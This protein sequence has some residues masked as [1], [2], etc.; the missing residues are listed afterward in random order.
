MFA[1]CEVRTMT[2]S[3][4][5][6]PAARPHRV[7]AVGALLAA[8]ALL[9]GACTANPPP[10]IQRTDSP[11]PT[12]AKPAK[13]TVVVAID[14]I[15]TGFNPHLVS[16]QS[17]AG[18]TVSS[19]VLPSPF[20]PVPN[21]ARPGVSDWVPDRSMLVAADVTSQVPFT[22]VYRIRDEAQWS[23][24]AP[25]AAEDFRYLWQQMIVQEGVVDPAGYRMIA[26]VGS[27]GG[28]KT[29]TVTMKAPYPAW[30]E[31]FTDLLPSHLVKDAPGGFQRGL[32]NGIA[33]SGAQ[34]HIKSVDPERDEILLDR[35]D[36]FWDQ[37]AKPDQV[38]LRRGGVPTQLAES[39]RSG[40][41]QIAEV[42]GGEAT[43]AQL[44]AIPG[45]RTAIALQPRA[46]QLVLN[47]RFGELTD[48][49]VRRGLLGLLDAQLLAT[50]SESTAGPADVARAL[51]LSPSDPGYA[52][53]APPRL[54]ADA[55][56]GLL[57][58]AGYLRSQ[59]QPVRV[60]R[61]N[62]QLPLRI[63]VAENDRAAVAVANTAADQLRSA[64]IDASVRSMAPNDLY[65]PGLVG[66]SASSGVV[67]AVVGWMRAGS[68]PATVLASRYGC[69]PAVAAPPPAPPPPTMSAS[70]KPAG[71]SPSVRSSAAASSASPSPVQPSLPNPALPSSAL[72]PNPVPPTVPSTLPP[73]VT[74]APADGVGATPPSNLSGVCDPLLQPMIDAALRGEGDVGRT[75]AD[76]EPKLWEL[77]TV[78]PISQDSTI[79]AAGPGVA[80]VSLG[81]AVQGG[82]LSD[83]GFWSR[84]G[85]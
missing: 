21:P 78:L 42:H 17:P 51:V 16:N 41:A 7:L 14:G 27:S 49:R 43:R 2:E 39:M 59:A 79:V 57:A 85:S 20:R 10:P 28:G 37:P 25:I 18:R 52:P 1:S 45:V 5:R 53:T 63:G 4:R 73:A 12:P 83:A 80:G 68:D 24:G 31:L 40:D 38:L 22:V 58:E 82:P 9:F 56:Y 19:L 77:A 13:N 64:G 71:P 76:A 50:V 36:R 8:A 30:R 84:L 46:L 74:S 61:N 65:G 60:V 15:G 62:K 81:G 11:K 3:R 70:A 66:G 69:P 33:S 55:A 23:D 48:I 54:P 26:D 72:P 32:A 67:D 6:E 44:A 29:V 34:F 35:N 75:I 47:G